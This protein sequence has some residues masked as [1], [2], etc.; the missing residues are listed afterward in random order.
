MVHLIGMHVIP[1]VI[2]FI[3]GYLPPQFN[4]NNLRLFSKMIDLGTS[5]YSCF[6]FV[7]EDLLISY[8]D[9]MNVLVDNTE[10]LG[11]KVNISLKFLYTY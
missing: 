5:F 3:A 8:M 4:S 11:K 10:I 7:V 9:N 6:L 1:I 2:P